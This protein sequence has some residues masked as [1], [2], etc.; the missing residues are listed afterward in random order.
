ESWPIVRRFGSTRTGLTSTY[1]SCVVTSHD[2]LRRH[3]GLAARSGTGAYAQA[4][5]DAEVTPEALPELTEA[6]LRELGL[7]LG[8]RKIV[9]KAIQDLAVPPTAVLPPKAARE[10][11]R[12]KAAPTNVDNHPSPGI[13]PEAHGPASQANHLAKVARPS[14]RRHGRRRSGARRR[15]QAARHPRGCQ[16]HLR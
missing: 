7:P 6:D 9:L 15:R 1:Q 3:L 8:P 2:A 13:P 14:R 16:Y 4:F 5:L 10:E 11:A 12:S